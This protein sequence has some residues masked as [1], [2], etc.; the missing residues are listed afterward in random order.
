M[1][2][3]FLQ[4]GREG[5][6][7]RQ[8]RISQKG[9]LVAGSSRVSHCTSKKSGLGGRESEERR[10]E[11]R[12]ERR[13]DEN[14][15]LSLFLFVRAKSAQ[16]ALNVILSIIHGTPGPKP[17]G[18]LARSFTGVAGDAPAPAAGR[19]LFAAVLERAEP[20]GADSESAAAPAELA[21]AG[22]GA[23]AAV[24]RGR[25]GLSLVLFC[26]RGEKKERGEKR[27]GKKGER[28]K[29]KIE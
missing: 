10:K 14:V 16:N 24:A 27:E 1:R 7:E 4:N 9:R 15:F 2:F 25:G 26:C 8:R 12:S 22:P 19:A 28:E 5:D 21:A 3:H 18:P 20:L 17:R 6:T 29:K 23:S 13:S 11:E